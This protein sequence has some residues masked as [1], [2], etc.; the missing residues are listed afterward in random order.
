VSR[1]KDPAD[2]PGKIHLPDSGLAE[3]ILARLDLGASG[4]RSDL[5]ASGARS[6]LGASGAPAGAGP[7]A[8]T[9]AADLT[10]RERVFSFADSLEGSWRREEAPSE[11]PE[12][13]VTFDLAGETYALP[14]TAVQEIVRPGL[15]TRVP[16]APA[17][18][19]GITNLRGRVLAVVDLRVRLG[20]P[21]GETGDKSRVLVVAARERTLGLLVDAARQVVKLLPSAVQSPPADIRSER[22][23]F[24]LGVYHL[25]DELVI[26]LD[27]DQVLLVHPSFDSSLRPS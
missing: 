17:P 5:G 26:L 16:H 7:V 8:G 27:V 23:D 25:A 11:R 9:S 21:A 22:T 20:L 13:W 10:G 15:I 4:A 1:R 6:D 2:Q 14:V 18:V 19:R 24:L 12:S 3:E